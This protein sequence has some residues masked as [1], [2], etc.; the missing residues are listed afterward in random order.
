MEERLQKII[1]AAGLCSRRKAEEL[2][3]QGHVTVNGAVAKL[4][5]RADISCDAICVK[6]VYLSSK[7]PDLV[8]LMLNKPRGYTCSMSDPHAQH[9]VTELVSGCGSR[10]YPVGRLDVDSQG[11][12][13]LT[14]DGAFAHAVLHPSHQVE[15]TYH[16]TVT[17]F[18]GDTLERLRQ[19]RQLDEERISPAAVR[20]LESADS[21][22]V[23]EFV[24]HEGRKRQIRRM[25]AKV[26][27]SVRRLCR[28]A[29]CGVLLGDLPEGNWRHLTQEEIAA[30]GGK[31]GE[32]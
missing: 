24:I 7:K 31:T 1:A 17:G 9:L 21:A 8:Y 32:K 5:D 12:L 29:E 18:R 23:L 14:N 3:V 22:V 27:L 30:L 2:I 11:L 15:K 25:C 4:G 10:V 16:V 13:L 26:G 19:I 28:V 6:G 20:V